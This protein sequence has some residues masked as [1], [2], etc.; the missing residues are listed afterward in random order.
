MYRVLSRQRLA[1]PLT[2]LLFISSIALSFVTSYVWSVWP[3]SSDPGILVTQ[4]CRVLR[5]PGPAMSIVVLVSAVLLATIFASFLLTPT[6]D[7]R[8]SFQIA[9]PLVFCFLG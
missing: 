6:Q 2:I 9:L 5:Q 7:R 3:D 8:V 4:V 1:L